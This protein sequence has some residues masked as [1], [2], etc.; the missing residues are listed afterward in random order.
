MTRVPPKRQP[1][2][3]RGP[4]TIAGEILDVRATAAFLGESELTVR[5]QISRG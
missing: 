3:G 5:S 4:R 2:W 1:G